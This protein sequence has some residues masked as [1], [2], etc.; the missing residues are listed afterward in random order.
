M[1]TFEKSGNQVHGCVLIND[2]TLC[3]GVSDKCLSEIITKLFLPASA[4]K[5]RLDR[6]AASLVLLLVTQ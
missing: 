2:V 3:R 1:S 4:G 5:S 6:D